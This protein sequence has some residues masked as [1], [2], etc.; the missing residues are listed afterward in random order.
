M[1]NIIVLAVLCLAVGHAIGRL[2]KEKKG[3]CCGNCG[4]CAGCGSAKQ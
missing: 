3:G 4:S 1:G 2:R